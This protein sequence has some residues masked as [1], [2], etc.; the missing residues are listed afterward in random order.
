MPPKLRKEL[1]GEKAEPYKEHK[2]H[3]HKCIL[4]KTKIEKWIC[5]RANQSGQQCLSDM[6][7]P[8]NSISGWKCK[9]NENCEEKTGGN[10]AICKQ[11]LQVEILVEMLTQ[12]FSR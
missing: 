2:I 4:K 12:I 3:C 10:F 6:N 5:T 9:R 8:T 11:C 7:R 1:L